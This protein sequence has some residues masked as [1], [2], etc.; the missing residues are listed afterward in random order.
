MRK[1]GQEGEDRTKSDTKQEGKREAE[2]I[3]N[4]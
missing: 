3:Q 4:M 1:K 2:E